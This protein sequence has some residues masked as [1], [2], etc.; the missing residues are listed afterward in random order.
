MIS[1][2][3]L[4]L[5]IGTIAVI[6]LFFAVVAVFVIRLISSLSRSQNEKDMRR[7]QLGHPSKQVGLPT[8]ARSEIRQP[9]KKTPI[10]DHERT[11]F[12]QT[13]NSQ[14][15]NGR[16]KHTED[17]DKEDLA[18]Q[19]EIQRYFRE[20]SEQYKLP[21]LPVVVTKA[22]RLIRDPNMEVGKLSRLLA[23]DPALVGRII[24]LSRSPIHGHR[25]L[26][27]NLEEG[28]PILG[29][30]TLRRVLLTAG[31][32]MLCIGHSEASAVLWDHSLATALAA[33]T[34]ARRVGQQNPDQAFL[35]GL[36][37]DVGQMV[38]LNAD[39]R[40]Y[41]QLWRETHSDQNQ[42]EGSVIEWEKKAYEFDH[43]RIGATVL[44]RWDMDR[45]M[46]IAVLRHHDYAVD[47]APSSLDSLLRLAD[48]ITYVNDLGFLSKP[49][50]PSQEV[51]EFFGCGSEEE[52]GEF[53]DQIRQSFEAEKS[54][55][56]MD[57][58]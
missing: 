53:G 34:L 35:T 6:L 8:Q 25:H 51:L 23:N 50:S 37:H 39:P 29:L 42:F 46:C 17:S 1:F 38:L 22:L 4:W 31:T 7:V 52:L 14:P 33:E 30:Q 48:Y 24:S 13:L 44:Y 41:E 36:L 10:K 56:M 21:P 47:R 19:E 45:E 26:P 27:E 11:L 15:V 43:A 5:D 28:I 32:Q 18:I 49:P 54:Q 58:G 2:P 20:V 40:G 16:G 55:L 57:T 12:L 9:A 3:I